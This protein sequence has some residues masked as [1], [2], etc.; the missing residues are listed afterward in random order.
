MLRENIV[1]SI[2][3]DI[4]TIEVKSV[5]ENDENQEY[6]DKFMFSKVKVCNGN[7]YYLSTGDLLFS[8]SYTQLVKVDENNNKEIL[9]DF[10]KDNYINLFVIGTIVLLFVC[11]LL[12][13]IYSNIK[14]KSR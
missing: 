3:K 10:T 8:P 7:K 12:L 5:E 2:N 14:R 11:I 1:I 13:L 9:F 6:L 4:T